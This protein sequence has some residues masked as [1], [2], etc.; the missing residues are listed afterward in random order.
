MMCAR[1][2]WFVFLAGI[3]HLLTAQPTGPSLVYAT[4]LSGSTP[5]GDYPEAVA[6]DAAG[7][8]YVTG[9]TSSNTFPVTTAIPAGLVPSSSNPC[10]FVVKLSPQGA[11]VYSTLIGGTGGQGAYAIAVDPAGKRV[12]HRR[13]RLHR[14]SDRQPS[15]GEQSSGPHR[16]CG[17]TEFDR[18][19]PGVFDISG[20]LRRQS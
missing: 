9:K 1:I 7:N 13:H 5:Q 8:V 20:R 19:R 11:L 10:V 15:A 14:L 4:Y 2:L 12:R 3:F 16:V 17:Q 18:D 6:A